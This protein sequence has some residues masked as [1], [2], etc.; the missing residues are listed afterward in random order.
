MA[1]DAGP[2][3]QCL[4]QAPYQAGTRAIVTAS[5]RLQL[6]VQPWQSSV[7]CAGPLECPQDGMSGGLEREFSHVKPRGSCELQLCAAPRSRTAQE[8]IPLE[9][10]STGVSSL[11]VPVKLL[12]IVLAHIFIVAEVHEGRFRSEAPREQVLTRL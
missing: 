7:H 12:L 11:L 4:K 3:L 8:V 10:D 5:R 9:H 6:R 2:T 1:D